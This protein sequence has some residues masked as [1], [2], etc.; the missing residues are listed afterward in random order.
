MVRVKK[1]A[2]EKEISGVDTKKTRTTS[3]K[4]TKKTST[5]KPV[6]KKTASAPDV[7][8]PV[9]NP[10]VS[11]EVDLSK[12][13]TLLDDSSSLSTLDTTSNTDE[14]SIIDDANTS[15]IIGVSED[16]NLW[17]AMSTDEEE[18]N[19]PDINLDENNP[20]QM[21]T[22]T[23]DNA[24]ISVD[25]PTADT[26]TN[27]P[28]EWL[29]IDDITNNTSTTLDSV[30]PVSKLSPTP[31][32]ITDINTNNISDVS[33]DSAISSIDP[34][35]S[36]DSSN[37]SDLSPPTMSPSS[38][39]S[40]GGISIDDISTVESNTDSIVDVPTV[41]STP[42][43]QADLT[44]TQAIL[45][46]EVSTTQA[47][48]LLN[49]ITN[50]TSVVA[51]TPVSKKKKMII[52]GA[53]ITWF[54]LLGVS[55]YLVISSF[56]PSEFTKD[57]NANL[58]G[59]ESW[60]NL[61][62]I[63]LNNTWI[64]DI[65]QIQ[66][67]GGVDEFGNPIVLTWATTGE[68]FSGES[69]QEPQPIQDPTPEFVLTPTDDFSEEDELTTDGITNAIDQQVNQP[70]TDPTHNSA[71]T[72]TWVVDSNLDVSTW[73]TQWEINKEQIDAVKNQISTTLDEVKQLLTLA[74]D[75]NNT[76]VMRL[77]AI[78]LTKYKDL[79]TAIDNNDYTSMTDIEAQ[80]S[81]IS[82]LLDRA[83]SFIIQ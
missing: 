57:L 81:E 45:T 55:A 48:Q 40:E 9:V 64:N 52:L 73:S 42:T 44:D 18:V 76:Q 11:D 14:K 10:I 71:D 60:E 19:L 34:S 46:D 39:I 24:D 47:D 70:T 74:K 69:D 61:L 80:M 63:D 23:V 65:T 56:F 50:D 37:D 75:N 59:V 54:L 26:S 20:E 17:S 3:K 66:V 12:E 22:I 36:V 41:V 51:A 72:G 16:K 1:I 38:P 25:N 4:T 7:V 27:N 62:G 53:V 30:S 5:K 32:V 6:S 35:L 58:L 33:K 8:A 49:Q 83:K 15:N 67:D 2:D 77:L 68:L 28:F 78:I 79:N 29:N 21:N 82:Y 43:P 13:N 31:D